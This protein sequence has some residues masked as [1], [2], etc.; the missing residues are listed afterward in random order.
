MKIYFP[1]NWNLTLQFHIFDFIPWTF[2]WF[3]FELCFIEDGRGQFLD[4]GMAKSK[5][6]KSFELQFKTFTVDLG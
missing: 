3:S 5:N 4:F 6:G 1:F 2:L